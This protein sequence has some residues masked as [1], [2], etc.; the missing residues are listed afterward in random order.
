M[1]QLTKIISLAKEKGLAH[2]LGESIKRRTPKKILAEFS[3]GIGTFRKEDIYLVKFDAYWASYIPYAYLFIGHSLKKAGFSYK[4]LHNTYSRSVDR[5][6]NSYASEVLAAKPLWVGVSVIT[7][8]SSYYSACFSKII[9]ENSDIPI[10]WG[11]IHPTILPE[12]CLKQNYVDY[13]ILDEGE[14][15]A[16]QFTHAL[17]DGRNFSNVEG[18]GYKED[19]RVIIKPAVKKVDLN[20]I[21]T[22]WNHNLKRYTEQQGLS[23]IT[24]RG[25]PYRCD[26]CVNVSLD[27]RKWRPFPE[28]KVL[29]D[30]SYLEKKYNI[31]YIHLN[32]DNFF[33]DQER[34]LRILNRTDLDYFAET[35]I[36]YITE[37]FIKN[38]AATK[39]CVKL[40][41]GGESGSDH[42][43]KGIHK[44]QTKE[45]ML[46]AAELIG[47]H[48]I[49]SSWSFIIGFPTETLEEIYETFEFMYLLEETAGFSFCKPGLY[50]PYPGTVLYNQSLEKGFRPPQTPEEWIICERYRDSRR[51]SEDSISY[52]WVDV[53]KLSTAL[54]LMAEKRPLTDIK[55]LLL[56]A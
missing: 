41:A 8:R 5:D 45:M 20:N 17:L 36:N 35:R 39:R 38:I 11:G 23:Y 1:R 44:G 13:V 14:E 18:I 46:K 33:V 47:R 15:R 21:D 51:P 30:I 42:T 2:L 4:I 26:F 40:M 16:I 7:G 12:Q 50:L 29:N 56:E 37:D 24:S 48:N 49:P 34:A 55:R 52:P 22:D 19:G 9:K 53:R 31:S 3:K 6:I 27:N 32:D 43:L 54:Q 25:C 28:S 10:V